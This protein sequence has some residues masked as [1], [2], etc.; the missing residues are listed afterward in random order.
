MDV[1]FSTPAGT[2]VAT[3]RAD[4]SGPAQNATWSL[5]PN[6]LLPGV[7]QVHALGTDRAGNTAFSDETVLIVSL[8]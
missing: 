1:V 2:T 6:G 3:M 7:Y 5:P 8:G 4:L